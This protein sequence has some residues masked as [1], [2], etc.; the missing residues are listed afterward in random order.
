MAGGVLYFSPHG[1]ALIGKSPARDPRFEAHLLATGQ[2]F[3]IAEVDDLEAVPIEHHAAGATTHLVT[4]REGVPT[5]V[6]R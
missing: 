1:G 2:A 4:L 6:R 3:E 5:V